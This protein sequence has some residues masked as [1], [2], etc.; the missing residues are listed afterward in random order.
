MSKSFP[1]QTLLD[2]AQERNNAAAA[3]LG[4]V[5]GHERDMQDRLQLLLDYRRE[6]SERFTSGA[7]VGMDS[8]GWRNFRQ[9]IN[10]LDVAIDKQRDMVTMA[11]QQVQTGQRHWQEQQSRLKSFDTLSQR[12][13]H[14]Q[15]AAEA[16]LEQKEQDNLALRGFS[17]ARMMMG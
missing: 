17:G 14:G 12:H 13:H 15:R 11:R 8:V 7:Q 3:Q 1:L 4:V 6:Y 10:T 16:R 9:F 5:N 2:L